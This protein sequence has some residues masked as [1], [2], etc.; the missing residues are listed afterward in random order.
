MGIKLQG[1]N[2]STNLTSVNALNQL[3]VVTPKDSFGGLTAGFVQM[4]SEVDAGSNLGS[5]KV[6]A[7][8]STDDFRLRSGLDQ[9]IFNATFEGTSSPT[10]FFFSSLTNMIVQSFGGFVTLNATKTLAAADVAYYRTHRMFPV[11]GTYPTYVDMWIRESNFDSTNTISEWGLIFTAASGTQQLTDAICFR[12]TSGG[13]LSAVIVNNTIDIAEV[14][15]NTD[16]VFARNGIG[17]YDATQSNHFLISIMNDIVRFWINDILVAQIKCPSA[18][19]TFSSASSLPVGFRVL[20]LNIPSTGRQIAIGFVNVSLGDQNTNKPWSHALVGSGQGAYQTQQGSAPN[21]TVLRTTAL[22][23][24]PA[25]A[26]V[27]LA[28]SWVQSSGPSLSNLGGLWTSPAM[29]TLINEAEYPIFGYL[30]PVGTATLPGKTLYVTGIRIGETS[31]TAAAAGGGGMFLSYIVMPESSGSSMATLDAVTT[32]SGKSIIMGGHG[33]VSGDVVGT[34]KPGFD[35]S[36]PSP[37]VIPAGKYLLIGVRL[38]G[39][40]TAN[41]LVVTGSVAVNGYFE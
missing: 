32:T 6:L 14:S 12:R 2:N 13:Q 16:K 15:I 3:R 19:A 7:L 26:T 40:I 24:H 11:F 23:G 39:T 33:F 25:S 5:R 36:F 41:T 21:P 4:S 29:S 18:Q 37:L 9:T 35:I 1:G 17:N 38:L 31:A 30:N 34:A 10:H 22:S 28:G 8:E 27:R 20:N